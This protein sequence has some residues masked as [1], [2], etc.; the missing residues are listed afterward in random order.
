MR[1]ILLRIT[2]E[3]LFQKL[4]D[5]AKKEERSVNSTIVIA[6]KKYLK[7]TKWKHY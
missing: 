1:K 3:E 4:T 6:I 7:E 2:N 5:I